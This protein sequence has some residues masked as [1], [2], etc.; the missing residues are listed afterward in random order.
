MSGGV[1][2]GKDGVL[3]FGENLPVPTDENG[4]EGVIAVVA[5]GLGDCDSAAQVAERDFIHFEPHACERRQG[6]LTASS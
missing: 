4:S 3:G 2:L 5:G 6:G 1:S